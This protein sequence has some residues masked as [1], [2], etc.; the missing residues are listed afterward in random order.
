VH[1]NNGLTSFL[2]EYKNGK[3]SEKN[4]FNSQN[5]ITNKE[6]ITYDQIEFS[7]ERSF[8]FL[9]NVQNQYAWAEN[10]NDTGWSLNFDSGTCI[11]PT[12]GQDNPPGQAAPS[13]G[14]YDHPWHD[15][16]M[17]E[18]SYHL[19]NQDI[20][21]RYGYVSKKETSTFTDSGNEIKQTE[22]FECDVLSSS[23]RLQN[24]ETTTSNGTIREEYTY[25]DG[26]NPEKITKINKI[27]NGTK[28]ATKQ[29]DYTDYGAAGTANLVSQIGTA[30]GTNSTETRL[31]FDYDPISKNI[32][33]AVNSS[34]GSIINDSYESYI[35]GYNEM[36]PVAKLVGIK[37]DQIP[38]SD[39]A[40]IKAASNIV[41]T[42]TNDANLRNAFS[43]LRSHLP[44]VFIT[45][46][47]YNPVIGV[48]ST[49]DPKGDTQ[50]FNYDDLGRLQNVKDKDGNILKENEYHYKPQN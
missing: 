28:V 24:K 49:T 3:I 38:V 46:Y 39:I 13:D 44:N 5:K 9:R 48:T 25:Y 50:Y 35:F 16:Y 21:G 30:K 4:I 43:D 40:A 33:T 11:F 15:A 6:A 37:Y 14:F 47:T 10:F 7:H 31:V 2:P 23:F 22:T 17:G 26:I 41:I 32:I 36:F 27:K 8:S 19:A 12:W 29:I 1:E 20:F 18:Y 42:P 45:T 34:A